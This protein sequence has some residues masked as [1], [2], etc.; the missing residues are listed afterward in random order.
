MNNK[1]YFYGQ[2]LIDELDIEEICAALRSDFLGQ[3][4]KLPEFEDNVEEYYK[5]AFTL[6]LHPGLE[7][8]DID[9]VCAQIHGVLS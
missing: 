4:P 9:Y 2:Q 8:Q 7:L 3:G 5:K 1:N 6:P